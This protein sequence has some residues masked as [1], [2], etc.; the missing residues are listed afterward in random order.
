MLYMQKMPKE[1]ETEETIG[2][3]HIFIISGIS[4]EGGRVHWAPL[5]PTIWF[6]PRK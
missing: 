4:I 1:T 2:F 6:L 3:C 5:L